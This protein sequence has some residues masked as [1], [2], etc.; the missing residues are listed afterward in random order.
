MFA[1]RVPQFGTGCAVEA[2]PGS[3]LERDIANRL[4][5]SDVLFG[6]VDSLEGGD[7][8]NRIA[9]FYTIPFCDVGVLLRADGRGGLE[10]VCG[11]VHYLLPGGSSLLSR[12]VYTG[13]ALVAESTKRTDPALYEERRK[14]GYLLGVREN[15]PAVISING[16]IASAGVNE[17][18]ARI[19]RFR[20]ESTSD[21]RWQQFDLVNCCWTHTGRK[22]ALPA[23]GKARGAWRHGAFPQL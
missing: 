9:T 14:E 2:Y 23:P 8:L 17:F 13:E 3:V 1:K 11:S 5:E 19:H 12:G 4:A 6:C 21:Q 18:L 10:T 7:V 22:G 16:F 15:S 20:L